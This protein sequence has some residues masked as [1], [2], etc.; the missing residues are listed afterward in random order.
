MPDALR[1]K[2][3]RL[4]TQIAGGSRL[5]VAY[6]GGVDST[7][8]L[9]VASLVLGENAVGLIGVSPS[10]PRR[11]LREAVRMAREFGWRTVLIET[12]EM[13]N[14][15][16]RRNPENRCYFCKKE[17]FTE[18]YQ[19]ARRHHY[20]RLADGTNLDDLGDFRP[21]LQA[22]RELRV[23]SPLRAAGFRKRDVR[24][25][26]AFLGLPTAEKPELACLASRF[27]TG[28]EIS[29]AALAQVEKAEDFLAAQG[30]RVFRVR[31]HGAAARVEL[32]PAE[33]PRFREQ[34]MERRIADHFREL[35]YSRVLLDPRGYRR[36]GA[37]L[38]RVR[39]KPGGGRS[40]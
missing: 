37:N 38:S 15:N 29:A 14:E 32:D 28:I 21:G 7:L 23:I 4:R 17:L 40:E 31:H 11:E 22:A 5:A 26:S 36:G 6:S 18:F 16:Y 12:H 13:E 20:P 9:H 24:E 3:Q 2:Y 25:L 19:Y 1:E 34:A 27:P 30:F 39:G 10:L 8:L 35:G 33:M